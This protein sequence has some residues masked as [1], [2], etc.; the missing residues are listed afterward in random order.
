MVVSNS[1]LPSAP[2]NMWTYTTPPHSLIQSLANLRIEPM[3]FK[4]KR[5]MAPRRGGFKRRRR[6]VR[7]RMRRKSSAYTSQSGVG[8]RFGFRSRRLRPRQW[9]SIL[10]RDTLSQT[11]FRSNNSGLNTITN[12]AAANAY[13]SAVFAALRIGGNQFFTTGGGMVLPDPPAATAFIGNIT[14]R[15]GILGMRV[16]NVQATVTAQNVR[17]YLIKTSKAFNA[18]SFPAN[19]LIGWDPSM[20]A[21]FQMNI[22]RVVL[23]R[24][25]L[26]ENG[27]CLDVKFRLR[28]FKIDRDLYDI[29]RDSFVWVVLLSDCEGAGSVLSCV[30]YFNISFAADAVG[31]S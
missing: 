24:E 2:I 22:G 7:R 14:V 31:T 29:D 3:A 18:V 21:D 27:N 17:V 1:Q 5:V 15:G 23:M 12:T 16:S 19:P 25:A 6:I 11:H 20:Q 30:P 26:L 10:W 13:Q 28:P 8:G 9:R 4:R